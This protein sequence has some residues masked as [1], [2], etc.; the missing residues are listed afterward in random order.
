M[1]RY[2]AAGTE[3]EEA[4]MLAEHRVLR[5]AGRTFSHEEL[6]AVAEIVA[7]GVGVSRTQLMVQ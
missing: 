2:A 7:K 6:G 1:V 3:S 5:V 4:S